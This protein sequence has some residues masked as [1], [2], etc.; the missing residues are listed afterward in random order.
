MFNLFIDLLNKPIKKYYYEN[1]ENNCSIADPTNLDCEFYTLSSVADNVDLQFTQYLI[2]SSGK[3]RIYHRFSQPI[4]VNET[5]DQEDGLGDFE[6]EFRW[7]ITDR[8][9]FYD[10]TIYSFQRSEWAK[11]LNTLR[12]QDSTYNVGFSY[13][14]ENKAY[15]AKTAPATKYMNADAY[16]SYNEHHKHCTKLAFYL[17]HN[18]QHYDNMTILLPKR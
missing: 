2:D 9:S 18:I 4:I 5:S 16:Y 14:Y 8:I 1:I 6:N 7:N 12:Y 3:E 11:T 15:R 13:L 17:E 10:D